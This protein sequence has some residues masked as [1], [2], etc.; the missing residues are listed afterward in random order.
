[1]Q[2]YVSTSTYRQRGIGRERQSAHNLSTQPHTF[3]FV[4]HCA[5]VACVAAANN[6]NKNNKHNTHKQQS[7]ATNVCRAAVECVCERDSKSVSHKSEMKMRVKR[8]SP[9]LVLRFSRINSRNGRYNIQT[10]SYF[11][12]AVTCVRARFIVCSCVCILHLPFYLL[13]V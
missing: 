5:V 8:E 10:D 3:D 7:E 9:L 12:S 6:N 1:M 4:I 2:T 11:Y 13:M